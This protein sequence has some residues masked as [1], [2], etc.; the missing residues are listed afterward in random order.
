MEKEE[1]IRNSSVVQVPHSSSSSQVMLFKGKQPMVDEVDFFAIKNMSPFN[2][3]QI[4][5]HHHVDV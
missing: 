5:H 1:T 2:H 3:E 4:E